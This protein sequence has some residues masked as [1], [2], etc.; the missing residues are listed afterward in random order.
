MWRLWLATQNANPLRV[1]KLVNDVSCIAGLNTQVSH[2]EGNKVFESANHKLDL[3]PKD[4]SSCYHHNCVNYNCR[5]E[6]HLVN[7]GVPC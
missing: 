1:A 3:P 6:H 4:E 2:L 5:R 7:V